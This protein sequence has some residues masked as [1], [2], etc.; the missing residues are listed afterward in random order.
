MLKIVEL[1]TSKNAQGEYVVLQNHGLTTVNLRGWAICTEAYLEGCIRDMT[2]E[3]FIFRE[4]ISIKPYTYVVLFSGQGVD[5][6]EPT[7]DGRQAYC[8]YWNRRNSVWRNTSHVHILQ[9]TA[10]RRVDASIMPSVPL[11]I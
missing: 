1:H 11:A 8:A 5:D 7:V 10:S 6:W 9:L 2:E 3:M 4:D